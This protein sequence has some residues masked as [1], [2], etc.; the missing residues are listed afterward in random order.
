MKLSTFNKR[1]LF[2][3]SFTA[4]ASIFYPVD[5]TKNIKIDF[6][7]NSLIDADYSYSNVCSPFSQ[8]YSDLKILLKLITFNTRIL[9]G[10]NFK[11][12]ALEVQ[13]VGVTKIENNV[14]NNL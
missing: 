2:R 5:M 11:P 4:I 6:Q 13:S 3:R 8:F 12:I 10:K 7:G 1:I 14:T 9:S